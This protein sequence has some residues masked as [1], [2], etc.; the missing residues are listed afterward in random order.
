MAPFNSLL[1]IM[2]H[3]LSIQKLNCWHSKS[4]Q[5]GPVMLFIL[6]EHV[7]WNLL[8]AYSNNLITSNGNKILIANGMLL[9]MLDAHQRI[10]D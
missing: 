5:F 1:L 7:V 8:G 6:E 10:S 9:C 3:D 4:M 2:L